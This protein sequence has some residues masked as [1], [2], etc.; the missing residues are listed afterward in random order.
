MNAAQ[1]GG[2]PLYRNAGNAIHQ[3]SARE[4]TFVQEADII[5]ETQHEDFCER[6]CGGAGYARLS[7]K[8][9]SD[10]CI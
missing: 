9:F 1:H 5:S 10:F 8:R 2:T 4:A 6:Y 7:S 3:M